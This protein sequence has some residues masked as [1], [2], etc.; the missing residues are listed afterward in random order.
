MLTILSGSQNYY[1]RGGSDRVYFETMALL[2][3]HGHQVI[4][5]AGQD[6]RNEPSQWSQ[7]FPETAD[8]D[9]PGSADLSRYVYSRP[10][11]QQIRRL[12]DQSHPDIAHLHIYYGKLTG[13]IL[14]PLRDAGI[15]IIQSLH[16]YKLICPVYTLLSNGKICAACQGK[17]FWRALP[18]RC[19]RN[20]LPRTALSVTESYVS[21]LLGSVSAIDHFVA[22][23]DFLRSM[24]IQYGVPPHKISTIYNFVNWQN[25]T[26]SHAVGRHYLYVGRLERIKGIFTLLEAAASLP[27]VPLLY[28]GDGSARE[29]LEQEIARRQLDHIHVIGFLKDK[30]LECIVA[31]ALCVILPS[32]WY[33]TFGL[34]IIEAFSAGRPAIGSR[35]GGIP[36]VIDDGKDGLLFEP[37]NVDDL[38]D[39]MLWMARHPSETVEM[40]AAG[41][42]KVEERFGADIYYE[43]LMQIYQQ[44]IAAHKQ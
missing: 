34:T 29:E 35:I 18:R 2:S 38:R 19:N 32:E 3:D 24:M 10:A 1:I 8:F 33:E 30:E 27:S 42:K 15:P 25:I 11:A 9:N 13:S 4:P 39:K 37:G 17:H 23:S 26:S 12:I 14:A 6:P 40:G 7:Y 44:A 21:R 36:E 22:V 20:S 16:E 31:E 41:R 28:V 5:F 43:K